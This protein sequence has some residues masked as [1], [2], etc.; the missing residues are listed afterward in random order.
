MQVPLRPDEHL[1]SAEQ[2]AASIHG[3]AERG[4][5]FL[6]AEVDGVKVGESRSS[7]AGGNSLDGCVGPSLV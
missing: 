4:D 7:P 5:L 1:I 2:Q 6:I 3:A